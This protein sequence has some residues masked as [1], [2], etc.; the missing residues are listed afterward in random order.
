MNNR[1]TIDPDITGLNNFSHTVDRELSP[2]FTGRH[3]ETERVLKQI[4]L[5]VERHNE[6]MSTAGHTMLITGPPGIGKSAF[7]QRLAT[8]TPHCYGDTQI[9]P[10]EVNLNPLRTEQNLNQ[11]ITRAIEEEE[12]PIRLILEAFGNTFSDN[13]GKAIGLPESLNSTLRTIGKQIMQ[14]T[15]TVPVVCILIDEIQT[16]TEANGSILRQLHTQKFSPPIL[17]VFAGLSNAPSVLDDIGIS[18]YSNKAHIPLGPLPQKDARQAVYQLFGRYHVQGS[19]KNKEALASLIARNSSGFP[20]H[21]HIGLA[22]ASLMLAESGGVLSDN[23]R[24]FAEQVTRAERIATMEREKFYASKMNGML[25]TYGHTVLDLI[26]QTQN[27]SQYINQNQLIDWAYLS[28]QRRNPFQ[29]KPAHEEAVE[30]V[31][32]MHRRGILELNPEGRVEVPIPSM[33][34]WLTG[35]YAKRCDYNA[36]KNTKDSGLSR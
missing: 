36:P 4:E 2:F 1:H 19:D 8:Y 34:T 32:Q 16:A 7:L 10:V 23:P 33:L 15:K 18:R 20:Q 31:K 14:H 11:Q 3:E 30:L 22:G 9:I 35:E 5:C 29:H 25:N 13:L 24:R 17:P 21:L 28:M 26:Y 6:R 12:S 27:K